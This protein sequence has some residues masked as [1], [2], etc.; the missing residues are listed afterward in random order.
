MT[1]GQELAKTQAWYA[2]LAQEDGQGILAAI[3]KTI[4]AGP[5]G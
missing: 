2:E 3:A 5:L 1:H 4:L